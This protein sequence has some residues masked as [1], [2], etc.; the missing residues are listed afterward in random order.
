MK[1]LPPLKFL[2]FAIATV[3]LVSLTLAAPNINGLRDY[4]GPR[5]RASQQTF[6]PK[7]ITANTS[8][9]AASVL[10]RWNQISVDA[11]GL[12]HMPVALGD[13]RIFGEQLGPARA[14]RAVAIVHIAMFDSVNGVIGGY[15]SFTNITPA[16][17]ASASAA[18]AQAAC[19]TLTAMFPSQKTTF[20]QA[21]ADDLAQISDGSAKTDG[22]DLG[23]RAAVAILAL[24]ANDGSA[25][26]EP[27]LGL[28][29]FPSNDPGKWRQDPIS[30]APIALGALWG[31][32]T[33][34][35]MQSAAQFRAPPPPALNSPEY[36]AAFN[37]VKLLGGDGINTPT[38]RTVDQTE[39]GIFW[40]YDGTPSLCAPPRLY[41]QIVMQI[42]QQ[43]G[44]ANNPLEL[45]RLL[46]LMN[47]SMADAGIA[48]WESKF[49][50]QFWRPVTGIRESDPGTGPSG[51][52]DGNS[53]T[54]G[55]ANFHPLGAPASNLTGPNFTPPFPSYPS[56]HGGFGG[57]IFQTLRNFYHTDDV[58]FTF[59]SDEFN[60][61][62]V[63]NAGHI[64]ALKPRHFNSFSQA[65]EENGQSRIYLGIHWSFDKTQAIVQGRKVAD[66]VYQNAF[67]GNQSCLLNVSTRM[68]VMTGERVLIGGFII[69]GSEP[70]KIAIRAIGPSLASSGVSPFLADPTLELHAANGSIIASNDNWETDSGAADLTANN[71]APSNSNEAAVVRTLA[72]GSYTAVIGGS[73]N[74]AGI[75][76]VE[77]YDLSPDSNSL[78]GNMSTRGFVDLGDNA[79]IGGFIVGSGSSGRVAIRA[80]GPSLQNAGVSG[81]LADPV[82]E[83]H[84]S[85]GSVIK[86]NDTWLTDPG[87]TQ[88]LAA[89]LAPNNA[90]EAAILAPL[91]PGAYTA[92]VRGKGSNTGVALVEAYNLP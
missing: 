76:L 12:D 20:D 38:I 35:V 22:I 28:Q 9:N 84:D 45:A 52:G 14:S 13:P 19:E 66:Y 2:A 8:N 60:G 48:V 61:T 30:Q 29:F 47:V 79:L 82:L 68:L 77:M 46:A 11:S 40:A 86:T 88:L 4:L 37:E 71:I 55:D 50:Y 90:G 85:N 17:N 92:V 42:A 36:A 59:T 65:E 49:F 51:S 54:T 16:K 25:Q 87:A 32:V 10:A 39:T 24:K 15:K 80:L 18:I 26:L 81:A 70:K 5:F 41:N 69:T 63:D 56:G 44:T 43:K 57:A 21:L 23:H 1:T 3:A 83:L 58:H 33:P 62:T 7:R 91:A 53:A 72:P 64:R 74:L 73:G 78:V 31:Q 75:G 27:R 6:A 89:G 67:T 34:F